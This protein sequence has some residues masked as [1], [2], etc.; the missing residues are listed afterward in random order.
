MRPNDYIVRDSSLFKKHE[1]SSPSMESSNSIYDK[2]YTIRM[3][4][5][6][7]SH[8]SEAR[9]ETTY[10]VEV[11]DERGQ[12]PINCSRMYKF[13]GVYN[14]EEFT[15][16]SNPVLDGA[17]S[18]GSYMYRPGDVVLVAC[19]NGDSREG[20]ILGSFI[21]PAR[22]QSIS[23]EDGIAYK[24]EFNGIETLINKDGEY[25]QTFKGIPTNIDVLN[26]EASG[27]PLPE[28]EYNQ[29]VGSSYYKWDK[30][31]SWE[32][33]DNS[34]ENPQSIKIDKPNGKIIITSGKTVLTIDKQEESYSI[35]NKKTTFSS[36]EEFGIQ[37]KKTSIES[38]DL[39]DLKA[40]DIKTDGKWDQK[41]NMKIQGDIQQTGNTQV[42]GN[43]TVGGGLT[44]AGE[45]KLGGGG[46]P[47]IY[48]IILIMGTGN[49]GAPVIS[50]ATVLK[51]ALTKAT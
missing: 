27:S 5:I 17:A 49:L 9:R 39:F 1:R 36:E 35:T 23:E 2:D 26:E 34:N 22:K 3:G 43:V 40:K 51:T 19:L 13:G 25:V 44:A 28:A 32:L 10:T 46:N 50:T 45:C 7:K 31:G 38:Q 8:Y 21:H 33:S 6:Q 41:G 15:R 11:V 42:T 16:Q 24:S 4:M 37:T 12:S 47:L 30:T 18:A 20:V 14:Y 29:E 48:D